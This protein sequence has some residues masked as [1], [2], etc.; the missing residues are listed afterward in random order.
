MVIAIALEALGLVLAHTGDMARLRTIEAETGKAL[1]HASRHSPRRQRAA[2]TT[3]LPLL[4]A[5]SRLPRPRQGPRRLLAHHQRRQPSSRLRARA[6]R[7]HRHHDR[8]RRR[9][10]GRAAVAYHV[11]VRP[12]RRD[13]F[14]FLLLVG[15]VGPALGGSRR[16]FFVFLCLDEN[17]DQQLSKRSSWLPPPGLCLLIGFFQYCF[18]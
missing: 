1:R 13:P 12:P 3:T 5:A 17:W 4:V 18:R 16:L 6:R 2:T 7:C 14:R 9:R 10:R 15:Y 11:G 8:R